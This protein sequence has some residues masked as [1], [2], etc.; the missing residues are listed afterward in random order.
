MRR[1][2]AILLSLC[3][4]LSITPSFTPPVKAQPTYSVQKAMEYAAAHW[5]DGKGLCAEFASRVLIAG[6]LDMNVQLR[7]YSC[8]K[9]ASAASGL[10]KIELKLTPLVD[11][12]GKTSEMATRELDGDILDAGDLVIQWCHTHDDRPH[13]I[14]CA[15][16]DSEG[17]AVFYGHNAA[18]DRK[19]F[20]LGDSMAYQ[21]NH[22]CDMRAYV[23][24]VS[25]LDPNYSGSSTI[26]DKQA[27]VPPVLNV[28][29]AQNL[30]STSVKI[31]GSC[32]YSGAKP[33]S[34]GIYM[35]TSANSM[36]KVDSDTINHNKNPFDIWY[37]INNLTPGTTYYYRLYAIAGNEEIT[38]QTLSFT[39]PDIE[40]EQAP[41]IRTKSPTNITQTTARINGSC[42]YSG[43]KPSSVGLHLG[44]DP[45]SIL[46][47]D[48]DTI[49]HNKNPFDIWYDLDNLTPD[50]EYYYQLYAIVGGKKYTSSVQSFRTKEASGTQN[51]SSAAH[52]ITINATG[53]TKLKSTS[54]QLN[55]TCRYG[56]V[57]PS[58]V[59]VYFG[60][61]QGSMSK[62]DSDNINHWKN[63][64][65]IWYNPSNLSPG[66]TYYYQLY[67]IVDGTE[68]TS[69]V[70]SFATPQ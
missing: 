18:M 41:D 50:T 12:W 22:S 6:G 48:S 14:I 43:T 2:S 42:S 52:D 30:T 49:N 36:S 15:G 70:V 34:V 31:T 58:S 46:E 55:G 9:A 3:I 24:H 21:H 59:G 57:R 64:F 68:Y 33:S 45:S 28:N 69:G 66:T 4:I 38:T 10:D 32:S 20:Q 5:N 11:Y 56:G 62:I 25:S 26:A 1:F 65:D 19:R 35:G 8:L 39:T 17:Y 53:V 37:D 27:P 47:V 29:S 60:T 51:T 13:V 23:L 63:P 7:T 54:V 40:Q 16:Y 67:A 61:S 44:S